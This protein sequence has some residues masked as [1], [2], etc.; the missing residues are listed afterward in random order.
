MK[1]TLIF[2]AGFIF[3]VAFYAGSQSFFTHSAPVDQTADAAA[4]K[5]AKDVLANE[6]ARTAAL[7][8]RE[9]DLKL[10]AANLDIAQSAP[11]PDD[12]ADTAN[13]SPAAG[14]SKMVKAVVQQQMEMKMAAL[15]SR[16]KLTDDQAQAI[17][18]LMDKQSQVA[19]DMA[20]KM[21]SGKMSRDEMQKAM[22]SGGGMSPDDMNQ[23]MQSI[24][25]PDQYT[26]YQAMQND[27]KKTAAETQANVELSQIQSSL[28]LTDDQ[29]D[30]VFTA[31]YGQ[32]A[33]QAGVDGAKPSGD[34]TDIEGQME[35][36]KA[37]L[38]SVLTPEQFET[39]SSFV[40]SQK[41]M[42]NALMGPANASAS[43]Q[44]GN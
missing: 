5:A 9:L 14:M 29:K 35:A 32:Y 44:P 31:L 11:K 15:K 39:Y 13:P 21:M 23:Q 4:I 34:S 37:A 3:G 22:K 25:S 18:D 12:A 19:Q 42:I 27:D 33:Q 10:K 28:Q 7:D 26:A 38:Q 8:K 17:Q 2:I 24:L 30:K 43:G 36:K 20:D 1:K 41:K 16:L 40:D 6:K